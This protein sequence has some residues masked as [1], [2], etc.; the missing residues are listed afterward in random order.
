V[1]IY[2]STAIALGTISYSVGTERFLVLASI[3]IEQSADEVDTNLD[4]I[5]DREPVPDRKTIPLGR[6]P[7]RELPDCD[8]GSA[9]LM[10]KILSR[11][12]SSIADIYDVAGSI[13]GVEHLETHTVPVMHEMGALIASERMGGQIRRVATG[14]LLQ[15]VTWDLVIP[16]IETGIMRILGISIVAD[17]GARVNRAQM[18]IANNSL[19]TAGNE[20]P[21][22]AWSV[23]DGAEISLR[24]V[25]NGAAVGNQALLI[26]QIIGPSVP[27]MV[28]GSGQPQVVGNIRF[29]GDT[30]AFG[31]GTVALT[32]Q[33]YFASTQLRGVRSV[34]LPIPGW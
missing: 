29:R 21:V 27:N 26:N 18:S 19:I 3:N 15:S 8:R 11:S 22:F 31:A 17:N 10:P 33:V 7:G 20:I 30:T 16:G 34:G 25:D 9:E 6:R 12:G 5:L 14:D 23:A 13:A 28:F 4:M 24:W 32:A 2:A 1:T